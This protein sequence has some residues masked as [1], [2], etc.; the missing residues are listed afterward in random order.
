[1]TDE[2]DDSPNAPQDPRADEARRAARRSDDRS[3]LHEAIR[4]EAAR[5]MHEGRESAVYPA[6]MRAAR[7]ITRR[8][9]K[10]RDLP[11]DAD[12]SATLAQFEL[13]EIEPTAADGDGPDESFPTEDDPRRF[14]L[15]RGLL[16]PLER[17]RMPKRTHPEGDGLYHSLQAYALAADAV[18]YDEELQAAAL[19]HDV[20]WAIDPWCV[21][22]AA[23]TALGPSITE[24]TQWLIGHLPEAHSRHKG[25][26]GSRARGRISAAA[27]GES[28]LML[29]DFDRRGR[30]SGAEAPTLDEALDALRELSEG[31]AWA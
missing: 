31:A 7:A 5:L 29:A 3:R 16:A 11:T 15:W 8:Y 10:P 1:M 26:L 17:V 27:D 25:E 2:P 21:T 24:R 22:P 6:K 9:V 23:L 4:F 28:L 30:R 19:L 12:V 13:S 18:P 20:G 14:A